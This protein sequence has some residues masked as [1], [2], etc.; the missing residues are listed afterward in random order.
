MIV[1]LEMVEDGIDGVAVDD[2]DVVGYV[3]LGNVVVDAIGVGRCM[4]AMW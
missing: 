4:V 2:D 1:S 3:E